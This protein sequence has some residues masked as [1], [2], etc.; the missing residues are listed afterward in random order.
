MQF[1]MQDTLQG[2]SSM[3]LQVEE[4]SKS[5]PKKFE[6]PT[7]MEEEKL[8]QKALDVPNMPVFHL[9]EHIQDDDEIEIDIDY[10]F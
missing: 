6:L 3:K 9:K 8:E 4:N 1:N 2:D 7:K 10:D 5:E